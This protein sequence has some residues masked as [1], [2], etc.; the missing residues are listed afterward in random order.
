MAPADIEERIGRRG[1][2]NSTAKWKGKL[3]VAG[4]TGDRARQRVKM[5]VTAVGMPSDRCGCERPRAPARRVVGAGRPGDPR[6]AK[7]QAKY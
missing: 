6:Q 2:L 5:I 1:F 4:R 3:H 7:H